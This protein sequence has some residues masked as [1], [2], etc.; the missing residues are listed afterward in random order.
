MIGHLGLS[1]RISNKG[2]GAVTG[3]RD[4]V[5]Q[6]MISEDFVFLLKHQQLSRRLRVSAAHIGNISFVSNDEK[7]SNYLSDKSWQMRENKPRP[8]VKCQC[9]FGN[10]LFRSRLRAAEL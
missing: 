6:R 8:C 3:E 2:I 9:M 7:G 5:Q 1:P 10:R 4:N